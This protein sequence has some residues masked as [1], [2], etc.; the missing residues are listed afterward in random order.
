[1]TR[2]TQAANARAPS[3]APETVA[4]ADPRTPRTM[5]VERAAAALAPGRWAERAAW[6]LASCGRRLTLAAL[7]VALLAACSSTPLP[8][9]P[10][11]GTAQQGAPAPRPQPGRVVPAPLGTVAAPARAPAPLPAPSVAVVTPLPGP[12]PLVA[13][14]FAPYGPEV[15]A[16]FPAPSVVYDTPGLGANRRAFTSNIEV[17]DWLQRL[18]GG[19][20]AGDTRSQ[21]LPIGASQQGEPLE[22][23]VLT[24]GNGTDGTSVQASNKPTVLLVGQQHGDEPAGSEALLVIAR[25]LSQGLL[26]PLLA[27]INVVIVPRANPDGAA[28]G[29]RAT[30]SGV[31]LDLDHLLLSTPEAQ[32]LARLVR[33]YRPVLVADAREY[34]VGGPFVQKLG[35]VQRHDALL[36]YATTANTPEFLTKASEEW[37][38]RPLLG[39]LRAQGLSNEWHYTV[40]A[41]PDDRTVSMGGVQPDTGRN[42]EGLKNAVS[43]LIETRGAGIGRLDLQ[44]R[45]HT[46]VTAIASLLQSTAERADNL[47]QVRSFVDRDVSALACRDQATVEAAP[48]RSQHDLTVINLQTG[49]D[50]VVAVEWDSSLALRTVKARARPC[51]YW[52]SPTATTAVE[53]LRLLG[54]Q[55]LRVAEPGALVADTYRETARDASAHRDGIGGAGRAQVT[56]ARSVLDVNPGSF[57]VP[58]SQPLGNLV[59][60]ALEPDTQ[61]SYYANRLIDDLS[62]VARVGAAPTVALENLD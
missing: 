25:E 23:L 32:A 10:A 39:A 30:A 54:V 2:T 1:M 59:F 21:L 62:S 9:W 41:E 11:N 61:H 14:P 46:Q 29:T 19:A 15:A 31:D 36:Q 28:A 44:R 48:T 56:L 5:R 57:Y 3:T 51:G 13:Q 22:A 35:G 18:A 7:P 37:Y 60:A 20:R 4:G 38:R 12:A 47:Q 55:V 17:H 40:S 42:V 50:R 45:V 16:R 49:L 33:D 8:P 27:R 58:L 34:T 26:E 53:R 43:Y 24:R 52:L 6:S